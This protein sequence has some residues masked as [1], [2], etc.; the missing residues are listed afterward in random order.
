MVREEGHL[1]V[2]IAGVGHCGT[3]WLAHAL[4]RPDDGI[5]CYH[6]QKMA[7]APGGWHDLL[8]HGLEH[9]PDDLF[10]PYFEFMRRKLEE[11]RVVADSNSWTF[12]T[13]PAVHEHLPIDL[14]V[15]LVRNGIQNVH[16][17]FHEN[18]SLPRNDWF[19]E[20]FIDS[21]RQLVGPARGDCWL[22]T[23]WGVWC[24]YWS[25]NLTM[26]TW[27]AGRFGAERCVVYRLEDLTKH[28]SVLGGLLA[29]LRP[30]LRVSHTVFKALS[31]ND[32]NRKIS[33]DRSPAALWE[34]W[35]DWQRETFTEICGL[36][37]E[38]YGYDLPPRPRT[39]W[40]GG[41]A[42]QPRPHWRGR[43]QGR[44]SANRLH[45][46]GTQSVEEQ[47]E[48][49]V[50]HFG[51]FPLSWMP[52]QRLKSVP[53]TVDGQPLKMDRRLSL[54]NDRR[55][56]MSITPPR[57]PWRFAA[58][59]ALDFDRARDTAYLLEIDARVT[60]GTIGFGLLNK[61]ENDFLYRVAVPAS[62]KRALVHLPIADPGSA[63]RF[64]VQQWDSDE[65]A[66]VDITGLT[67]WEKRAW[68]D[69]QDAV[70]LVPPGDEL[71]GR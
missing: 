47:S 20:D 66:H 24:F 21:Y 39:A 23:T 60:Q 16:S 35:T 30:D 69:L 61:K 36:C 48:A 13:I 50:Y 44:N 26:P 15:C 54:V 34:R 45:R 65:E 12:E 4:N 42:R 32:V 5:V 57:I 33:G 46:Y 43:S 51:N 8:R 62:R 55:P 40:T 71:V 25:L 31:R 59:F 17:M 2:L 53:F 1:F 41:V 7:L 10:T 68:W 52:K 11:F 64:V 3:K 37:M 70:T 67:V 63:G 22:E 38:H 28:S 56:V 27:L 9:G 19:Y 18:L 6:E 14:V 58:M 29:R 49:T